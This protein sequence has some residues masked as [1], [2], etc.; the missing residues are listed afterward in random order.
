MEVKS[1]RVFHNLCSSLFVQRSQKPKD[2]L[3]SIGIAESGY[4]FD[5]ALQ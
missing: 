3:N 5:I 2:S 4:F 1:L